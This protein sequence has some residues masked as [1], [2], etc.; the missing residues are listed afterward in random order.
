MGIWRE[1][2]LEEGTANAKA[3]G[4]GVYYNFKDQEE[5]SVVGKKGVRH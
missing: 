5:G 2:F 4:A 3:L 1:R